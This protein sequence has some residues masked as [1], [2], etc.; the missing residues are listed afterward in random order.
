MAASPIPLLALSRGVRRLCPRTDVK[1]AALMPIE[2]NTDFSLDNP[3]QACK[4]FR[5]S[6]GCASRL[7]SFIHRFEPLS[8]MAEIG[9]ASGLA[10]DAEQLLARFRLDHEQ[11][12]SLLLGRQSRIGK[13]LSALL[14]GDHALLVKEFHRIR[15]KLTSPSQ[16]EDL[17]EALVLPP[18][19]DGE[20]L[21]AKKGLGLRVELAHL[22]GRRGGV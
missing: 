15:R 17:G 7:V 12:S 20:S 14:L 3:T 6:V 18:L 19:E 13:N 5:V 10:Q 8:V 9:L 16:R 1:E 21:L 2:P 11:Q 22:I 4:T